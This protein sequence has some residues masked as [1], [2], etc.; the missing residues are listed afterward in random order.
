MALRGGYILQL[1]GTCEGES[2]HLMSVL[3][4]LS[5]IVLDNVKIPSENSEQIIPFLSR[6]KETYGLPQALVQNSLFRPF[7]Y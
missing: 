2:P 7:W 1:D 5:E 3:D 6:I 4:G